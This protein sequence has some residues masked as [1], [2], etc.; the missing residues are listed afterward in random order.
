MILFRNMSDEEILSFYRKIREA[1]SGKE[2]RILYLKA[3]D[4]RG[5]LQVIRKDRSDENGVEMWFPLM[6]GFFNDSPYAKARGVSGEE[7]LIAHF[8]HRQELELRIC[9]VLFPEKTMIL[10]SK[11]YGE[12]EGI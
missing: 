11:G 4:L 8:A 6:M 3:E 1:L 12:L 10:P 9:E 5:N 7:A 2:F